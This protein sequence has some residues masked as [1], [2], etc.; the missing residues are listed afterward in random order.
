MSIDNIR[1]HFTEANKVLEEFISNGKNFKDIYSAGNFML[2]ALLNGHKIIS[3]G[4]GGSMSDA[5]HFAEEFTGR[6]RGNRDPLPAIAISDPAY[7]TCTA[8]DYGYAK[9]FSRFVQGHGRPD[10]VLFAI[11]TSGNS[12][13]VV[14]A[15]KMAR[16]KEMIVIG[17]TGK[18]GGELAQYC[19]VE[20][21]APYSEYADRVQEIHIKVIHSLIDFVEIN[22]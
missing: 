16:K 18:D 1:H 15:A 8:N 3:C 21:R 14:N 20:I 4:N 7:L 13:N 5:M 6:F 19:N 9:V 17:L 22:L 12:K 2:A 11:S 10:D